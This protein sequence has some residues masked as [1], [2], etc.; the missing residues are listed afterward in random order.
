MAFMDIPAET[1]QNRRMPPLNYR[2]RHGDLVD[3][4]SVSA[5]ELKN[6]LGSVFEQASQVGAVAITK[7]DAP[8]AV[9]VSWPE[10]QALIQARSPAIDT[11]AAEFDELLAGMQA[12]AARQGVAAAFDATPA[13]LAGAA[14]R[15]ARPR[16][17][18]R[19]ARSR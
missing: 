1:A 8:K 6:G 15:A 5:S 19:A 12:P 9:L 14:V 3:V 18:R 4:P 10:F 16:K 11:L 2:N 13:G 7:H 17:P